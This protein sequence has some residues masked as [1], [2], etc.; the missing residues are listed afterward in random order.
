M[1]INPYKMESEEDYL[2]CILNMHVYFVFFIYMYD[3]LCASL[4]I[5]GS[6]Y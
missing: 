6:S 5:L 2:L 3:N 1:N 4:A